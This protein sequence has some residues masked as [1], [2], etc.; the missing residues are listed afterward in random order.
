MNG[1]EIS[2]VSQALA[3]LG[4]YFALMAV[5]AVMVEAIIGWLK[6]SDRLGLQG[7]PSPDDVL[8][9]VKG[10]LPEEA[11][12]EWEARIIALN[13][14]LKALGETELKPGAN[15]SQMAEAIGKATTKYIKNDKKRRAVIRVLA[16]LLGIGFAWLFQLNTFELLGPLA[17]PAAA[18][19]LDRIGET[20]AYAIGIVLSGLAAS[21]GSSFWHDQ[22]ARLR[23]LKSTTES[24]KE[25]VGAVQ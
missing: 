4:V 10:W 5:L 11:Q 6:L 17:Q 23:Q 15:A 20:Y 24:V 3:M 18:A 19:V 13:K 21:A 14:S 16:I 1:D 9:E 12:E 8:N 7:K 25:L 2:Q 22:S